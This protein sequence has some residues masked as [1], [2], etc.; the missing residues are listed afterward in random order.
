MGTQQSDLH[1]LLNFQLL[2]LD[3]RVVYFHFLSLYLKSRLVTS[4]GCLSTPIVRWHTSKIPSRCK[5]SLA[6][7]TNQA[8]LNPPFPSLT[9]NELS[10]LHSLAIGSPLS[11]ITILLSKITSINAK[12]G[13][14]DACVIVGDL[15]KEGSDG[16]EIDGVKCELHRLLHSGQ[17]DN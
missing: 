15:F 2:Q 11:A 17:A 13:P 7:A 9:R 8:D 6:L 16:S 12:H 4:A 14:F 3:F 5:L 1:S 10:S